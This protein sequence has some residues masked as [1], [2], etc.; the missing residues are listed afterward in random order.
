MEV[1]RTGTPSRLL[2]D[3]HEL[4]RDFSPPK[5]IEKTRHVSPAPLLTKTLAWTR[6]TIKQTLAETCQ[7]SGGL[8]KYDLPGVHAHRTGK[9]HH[10]AGRLGGDFIAGWAHGRISSPVADNGRTERAGRGGAAR[11]GSRGDAHQCLCT[12]PPHNGATPLPAVHRNRVPRA[13]R[14]LSRRVRQRPPDRRCRAARQR[15]IPASA[16]CPS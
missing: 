2:A 12:T 1:L 14:L 11:G 5:T 10:R 13:G 16:A 15:T 9:T 4:R 3:F 8:F 6:V 7:V